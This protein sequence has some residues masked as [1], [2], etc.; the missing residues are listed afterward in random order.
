[1]RAF[2]WILITSLLA[3]WAYFGLVVTQA[4]SAA[5]VPIPVE[6]K[7]EPGFPSAEELNNRGVEL[8]H[9]GRHADA[10]AY[11]ERAHDFRPHDKVIQANLE[12]QQAR[13]KQ[14]GWWRALVAGSVLSSVFVFGGAFFRMVRGWIEGFHFNRL[15]VRGEPRVRIERGARQAEIPLRF[16]RPVQGLVRRHPLT[17]VWSSSKHGKHMKSQPPVEVDGRKAVVRLD[18]ERLKRLRKFPGDWKGFLYLDGRP[19][20]EATAR[21]G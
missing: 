5:P 6:R 20:G 15:H 21:V 18:G 4:D 19:V 10:L 2:Y 14:V 9:S 1:M 17:V 8:E 11:L 7:T 3:L 13:V 16:N 12:R